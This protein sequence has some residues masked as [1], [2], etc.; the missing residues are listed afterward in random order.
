M[1]EYDLVIIG[2]GA[3]AFAAA[4]KANELE[5]KT[6]MVNKGLPLGGTC[7]NVGCV[8]SKHLLSVGELVFGTKHHGFSSVDIPDV[9]FDFTKAVEEEL[10]LAER[11]RKAKYENVL[12][13]LKKVTLIEGEAHFVSSNEVEVDGKRFKGQKFIIAT[14][15]VALPPPVEGLQEA[16]FITHI[17]AL[18]NKQLPKRMIIIGAGPLGLEFAQMFNNFGSKVDVLVRGDEILSRTEPEIAYA[19]GNYLSRDGITI[20]KRAVIKKVTKNGNDKVV[21]IEVD[22][23]PMELR[24]DEI[25]VATGKTPNTGKLN[26]QA[27]GVEVDD[28]KAIKVNETYQTS[29]PH[30]YAV[31][32][33]IDM[34]LRLETTAGKEG[35]YATE[36]A[37]EGTKKTIDYWQVPYAVFTHPAVAG[38]GMADAD[39]ISSGKKCV[40]RT[41]EFAEVP[42]AQIIKDTR[43]VIKMVVTEEGKIVG[44]HMVAPQAADIIN[45]A[46]YII[47]AGMTVEDVLESLPVF[48]TLSEAMKMVAQSYIT[49]I[50]KLSCCV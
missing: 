14:G 39:V 23:K 16:G 7:V 36:N 45:Q 6:L 37:L 22:G 47:K 26:L 20:W 24:V 44:V 40:C 21:T 43:G 2:G 48:P 17:D 9:H 29:I 4:I 13:Q 32:D 34:P 5:A 8:P 42:K 11:L 28:K 35:S 46:A 1:D 25:L 31:G 18:R 50:T 41:V 12:S 49:D 33:V 15:S 10:E 38:V 30:I 27:A 19:L 3:G